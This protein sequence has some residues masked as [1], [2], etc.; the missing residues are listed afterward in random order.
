[1]TYTGTVFIYIIQSNMTYT[2]TVFIDIIQNNMTYTGTVFIYIIQNNMT[3]T[4]TV[5]IYIIQNNVTY[6]GAVVVCFS[7]RPDI[8]FF[9]YVF[10]NQHPVCPVLCYTVVGV[11]R[12]LLNI[13]SVLFRSKELC[14]SRLSTVRNG[15]KIATPTPLRVSVT[16]KIGQSLYLWQFRQTETGPVC[17]GNIFIWRKAIRVTKLTVPGCWWK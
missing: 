6:T 12:S 11:D 3:Y 5:F 4:R 10:P 14:C 15:E 17:T 7:Q 9:D 1:M 2:R 8:L 13:C 16:S